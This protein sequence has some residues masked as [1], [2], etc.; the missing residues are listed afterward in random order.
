MA[1]IMRWEPLDAFLGLQE[2]LNR[3]WRGWMEP[4]RGEEALAGIA[5]WAPACDIYETDD[6]L[7]VEAE[8]PGVDPK[9][10][11]VSIEE[12]IL[13]LR[14]SKKT[15]KEVKE[16][17]YYRVERASGFFERAIRLPG[18]VDEQK[19]KAAYDNGVLTISVP[20]TAPKKAKSIPVQVEEKGKKK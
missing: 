5:R 1:S 20:K 15:E 10:I 8:L 13:T 16:E 19:V 6:S 17:N 7:V 4:M 2:D 14:G 9:D 11:E 12:G 18:E 3:L